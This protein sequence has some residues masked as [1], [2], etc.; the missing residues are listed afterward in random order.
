M[1]DDIREDRTAPVARRHFIRMAAAGAATS[2]CAP[3]VLAQVP[4]GYDANG[5]PLNSNG[6]PIANGQPIGQAVPEPKLERRVS[7]FRSYDWNDFFSD[8]RNGVILVDTKARAL[9][10][11]N[12]EGTL[13][14]V[15][16]TSV[17]LTPELTRTGR[18]SVTRKRVGPDW[19][20]TPNMLKRNPDLPEYVG[21][22]PQNP[23]GTHALYLSW[24][25]Y[26]IHG[27][28]DTRKIG[29]KSSNGCI[30]LYNEQIAELFDLAKVGTQVL[31]I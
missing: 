21:P 20:P 11:W 9:H 5:L 17:P 8:R 1:K 15:Y 13:Y 3:A 30:G 29:R 10:F 4:A 26:R 16:P 2:L 25:Y 12:E 23:L 7:G 14:N 24:R 27:T 28:N 22:G 19:R 31:L 6:Q 18:T